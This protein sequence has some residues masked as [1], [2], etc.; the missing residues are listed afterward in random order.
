MRI[1]VVTPTFLPI[2]GGAE[3]GIYEI[4]KRLGRYHDVRILTPSHSIQIISQQGAEDTYFNEK[5]FEVCHFKDVLNLTKLRGQRVL[6]KL[7]PPF[8][9]SYPWAI[10]KQIKIFHPDL[11]IFHYIVPA[12]LALI[13]VRILTKI[14]IVL[15][16]IGRTDVLNDDNLY[17]KKHRIYFLSILKFTSYVISISRYALGQFCEQIPVKII[18][19]GVDT[20][21]FSPKINGEKVRESLGIDKNKVILFAL[22]RL[23]K[24]KRVD[25]LIKS[26]KYVLEVNKDVFL[27]IGGKGYEEQSLKVLAKK[28][29]VYDNVIFTG[30]ISEQDIPNYFAMSDVFVFSSPNETFGIVIAQG[31]ASGKPIVAINSTAIP[32]V[33]DNGINGILV[34]SLN[35]KKFA[36]ALIK[37]LNSKDLLKQYS[38]DGRKKAIEKYDWDIIAHQYEEI[39]KNLVGMD[40]QK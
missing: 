20:K 37:L 31:M 2:I 12:G 17:F 4:C 7:I 11:I 15:S 32:E 38:E 6:G 34:E 13:M 16:L 25:I 28:I 18:P 29:G 10:F 33:V 5:N 9:I 8:S 24:V 39:F 14:P 35:P 23:V 19:Y 26:L 1:L 21:R 22:Q 40:M 36:A 3:I 30:H 27:I